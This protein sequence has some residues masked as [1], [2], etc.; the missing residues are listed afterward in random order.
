V[1][2][3]RVSLEIAI[4]R[5]KGKARCGSLY[6]EIQP[7]LL[8]SRHALLVTQFTFSNGKPANFP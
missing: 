4:Q 3:F 5:R 2:L 6:L 1:R 7:D 8:T